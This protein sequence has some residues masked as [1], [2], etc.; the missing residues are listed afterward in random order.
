MSGSRDSKTV[1]PNSILLLNNKSVLIHLPE[2]RLLGQKF[3]KYI[4]LNPRILKRYK[5]NKDIIY[6]VIFIIYSSQGEPK[7][8]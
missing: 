1:D 5:E 2:P 6:D 7:E 4:G 8:S 3:A